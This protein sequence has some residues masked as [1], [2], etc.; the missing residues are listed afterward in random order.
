MAIILKSTKE[1]WPDKMIYYK[2]T[3]RIFLR[4][5]FCVIKIEQSTLFVNYGNKIVTKNS[6]FFLKKYV[7]LSLRYV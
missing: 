1:Q 3:R 4:V 5:I 2:L 7:I 6:H